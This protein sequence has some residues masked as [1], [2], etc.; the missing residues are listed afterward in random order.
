MSKDD[1]LILKTLRIKL[2]RL[3]VIETICSQFMESVNKNLVNSF[4]LEINTFKINI[5]LAL[6]L[7]E[8]ETSWQ[9]NYIGPNSLNVDSMTLY[10]QTI[11][12]LAS[13]YLGYDE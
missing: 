7:R 13:D 3:I 4:L 6:S 8:F 10:L 11:T 12:K 2:K 5:K 1:G 9:E